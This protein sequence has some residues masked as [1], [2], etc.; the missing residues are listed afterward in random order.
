[1]KMTYYVDGVP[2]PT[3]PANLKFNCP[4]AKDV[5]CKYYR[6][7]IDQDPVDKRVYFEMGFEDK[8]EYDVSV[9]LDPKDAKRLGEELV[10]LSN[11][12]LFDSDDIAKANKALNKLKT[13]IN[14]GDVIEVDIIII[15]GYSNTVFDTAF[16][17]LQFSIRYRN[18]KENM[19]YKIDIIS[20]DRYHKCTAD[21]VLD[22]I[23]KK[24]SKYSDCTFNIDTDQLEDILTCMRNTMVVD[25]LIEVPENAIKLMEPKN[26]NLQ[27]IVSDYLKDK[28][29]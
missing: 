15:D 4:I 1:M 19:S 11:T 5:N 10:S 22:K 6:F 20:T 18:T 21:Q 8:S 24:C 2:T 29:K 17:K 27:K 28:K 7:T 12:C 14:T 23:N 9:F 3:E 16:G 25:G 13:S 26:V